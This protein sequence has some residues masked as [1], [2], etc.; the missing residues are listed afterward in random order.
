[1]LSEL[2]IFLSGSKINYALSHGLIV[3]FIKLQF[4]SEVRDEF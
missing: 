1:M 3:T 2:Q 4:Q